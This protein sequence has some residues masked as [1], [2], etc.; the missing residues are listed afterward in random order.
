MRGGHPQSLRRPAAAIRLVS[1]PA[2]I[3][4]V[5]VIITAVVITAVV[6]AVS[7][8]GD[9]TQ[10]LPQ[11]TD[12]IGQLLHTV[13]QFV[14]ATFTRLASLPF[15]VFTFVLTPLDLFALATLGITTLTLAMFGSFAFS[16]LTQFAGTLEHTVRHV[17]E[18]S[19]LKVLGSRMQQVDSLDQ[20]LA[21]VTFP[22]LMSAALLTFEVCDLLT[23]F[24]L[25][26]LCLVTTTRF[27]QFRDLSFHTLDV[28]SKFLVFCDLL[29]VTTFALAFTLSLPLTTLPALTTL[30]VSVPIPFAFSVALTIFPVPISVS[31]TSFAITITL[32]SFTI[33]VAFS[34]TTLPVSITLTRFVAVIFLVGHGQQSRI[35]IR[36]ESSRFVGGFLILSPCRQAE[37]DS[38]DHC[39]G[40][41]Q[42]QLSVHRS[43]SFVGHQEFRGVG[44]PRMET[45][46]LIVVDSV[47]EP[48]SR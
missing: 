31:F 6:I 23:Q 39:T 32:A 17:F 20:M 47:H 7:I 4:T 34:F 30:P 46:W 26:S 13:C 15:A 28:P 2:F 1:L 36:F 42:S 12:L 43:F 25:H 14:D 11:L 3:V 45:S 10:D 40:A 22:I 29:R 8:A 35:Q 16:V 21:R 19:S 18:T 38:D 5:V 33:T 24:G 44:T 37:S 41:N 9:S 48:E 27:G